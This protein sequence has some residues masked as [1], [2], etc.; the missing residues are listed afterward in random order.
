IRESNIDTKKL[1]SKLEYETIL[2]T[3]DKVIELAPNLSYSYYNRGQVKEK[4][5]DYRAAILDYNEAVR[6]YPE[7]AEAYYNR[8]LCRLR[9]ND[10]ERGLDD[11]RKAGELGIVS[12]YSIIKRMTE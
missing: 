5:N 8:G 6:K 9:V 2:R 12:A 4:Y 10:T 3:Y 11:L 1:Q 7:F